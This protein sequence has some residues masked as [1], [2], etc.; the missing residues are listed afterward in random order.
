MSFSEHFSM[1]FLVQRDE[2]II[3]GP[4]S[5]GSPVQPQSRQLSVIV[6]SSYVD[7]LGIRPPSLIRAE[8]HRIVHR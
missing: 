7:A 8:T 1:I 6:R 5:R 4:P 3:L 2:R